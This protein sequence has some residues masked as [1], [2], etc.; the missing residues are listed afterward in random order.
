[1][2]YILC[3]QESHKSKTLPFAN[4]EHM[5]DAPQTVD[6]TQTADNT[7]SVERHSE[8]AAP[9]QHQTET[10]TAQAYSVPN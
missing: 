1:M 7:Q 4:P 6:N 10:T 2:Y 3:L 8:G 9:T 5:Y